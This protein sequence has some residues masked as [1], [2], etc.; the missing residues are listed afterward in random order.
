MSLYRIALNPNRC[1]GCKSCLVHCNV[2]NQ[3]PP[4][5]SLNRI[6]ALGPYTGPDGRP[7]MEFV[8][9][10]CMQC[11]DPFCV[12]VCPSG[13]LTKRSEDGLVWLD[14]DACIGCHRCTEACP[15]DVPVFVEAWGKV[16]KCDY[17]MDRVDRGLDPACVTGCTAKALTFIR[18]AR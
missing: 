5:L 4:G 16:K 18:P 12:K 11:D 1:I 6:K 8:Y 2:K 9:Q 7:R 3:L 17:C 10:N 15:W 14:M 13:A